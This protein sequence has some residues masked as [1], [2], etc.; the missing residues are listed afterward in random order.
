MI[1]VDAERQSDGKTVF[2]KRTLKGSQ[3]AD[4]AQFLTSEKLLRDPHNH[5]VP[6]LDYFE[7]DSADGPAFL[8][9]PLLRPFNDPPFSRVDEVV[10][11]MTQT[12]EVR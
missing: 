2:V 3:E 4:I 7:D 1:G 9:M 12:L 10:D 8:V 5:C 11:F 6:I